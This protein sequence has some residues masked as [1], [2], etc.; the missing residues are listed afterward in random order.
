MWPDVI[1]PI[2]IVF[3]ILFREILATWL[4]FSFLIMREQKK[5]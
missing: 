4:V 1:I 5:G 3:D 2:F